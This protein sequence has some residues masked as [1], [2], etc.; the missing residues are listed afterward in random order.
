[1]RN[2]A[3]PFL[4]LFAGSTRAAVIMGDLT[5]MAATRDRG[6]FWAAY[7]RTVISLIWR[8]SVALLGAMTC[9]K[10]LYP[11][12]A[13]G[14]WDLT[15]Y[16]HQR[17]HQ[18]DP[19]LFGAQNFHVSD[20]F[21][22]F[23]F[24]TAFTLFFALPYILLRFGVRNRLAYLAGVL[25]LL[26]IPIYTHLAWVRDLSGPLT[27]LIIFTALT[28][29]LWRKPL[30]IL[31]A[32]CA[33]PLAAVNLNLF[34]LDKVFH[35]NHLALSAFWYSFVNVSDVAIAVILCLSLHRLLLRQRPAFA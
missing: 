35:Q 31:T 4:A 15:L 30:M 26:N 6:W 2:L 21:F 1:M 12:V 29:P 24:T 23:A 8:T 7:A 11:V 14:V 9:W 5:E 33:A 28:L 16:F 10:F 17:P 3:E 27:L 20:F 19:G 18:R 13:E 34:A 25:F 22:Q 32:T